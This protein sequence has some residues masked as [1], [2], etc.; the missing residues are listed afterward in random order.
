MP[1]VVIDIPD[2]KYKTIQEGMYAGI[3]DGE[4]YK[5]IKNGT[6]LPDNPTN[7]DMIKAMFP[8]VEVTY[9][10]FLVEVELEAFGFTVKEDWW[11]S[12]YKGGTKDE[13]TM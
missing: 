3:L 9:N 10:G 13:Y 5:A 4:M 11:N 12:P 7:G 1:K 2:R 8:E 6:V